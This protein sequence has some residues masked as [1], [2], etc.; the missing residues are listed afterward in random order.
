MVLPPPPPACPCFPDACC[1]IQVWCLCLV[2]DLSPFYPVPPPFSRIKSVGT[3]PAYPYT[4]PPLIPTGTPTSAST[5][6]PRSLPSSPS[7]QTACSS[8]MPPASPHRAVP[9]LSSAQPA[10]PPHS[11]WGAAT[12]GRRTSSHTIH[13]SLKTRSP[14]FHSNST[15]LPLK[16]P[17]TGGGGRHPQLPAP[18]AAHGAGQLPGCSQRG[19]A[20]AAA[21]LLLLRPRRQ[22]DPHREC[23]WHDHQVIIG[24]AVLMAGV[25]QYVSFIRILK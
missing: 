8:S 10:P 12:D 15:P 19:I 3:C 6:T 1:H 17:P 21:D 7:E 4:L 24:R 11:R 14:T 25:N 20:V 16:S 23:I 18:P 5:P 13:P 22:G 9:P 2:C